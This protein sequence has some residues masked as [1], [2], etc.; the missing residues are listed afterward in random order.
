MLL[1]VVNIHKNLY[2]ILKIKK[3]YLFF[4]RKPIIPKMDFR[5][6]P[7]SADT[8]YREAVARLRVLLAESYVPIKRF[9]PSRQIELD[10]AGDET[11]N[12]SI[13]SVISRPSRF[14]PTALSYYSQRKYGYSPRTQLTKNYNVVPTEHERTVP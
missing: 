6:K 14:V 4:Y 13:L 10:S 9:Y 1:F 8:A 7:D 5:K 3:N 2:S 11:D 12:Q